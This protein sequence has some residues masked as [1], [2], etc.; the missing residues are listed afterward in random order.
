[1]SVGG[2][3]PGKGFHRVI[4]VLPALLQRFPGLVYLVVGGPSLAGDMRAAL[5][6]Q[7]AQL[8]LSE[9]VRFMG[10]I[11]PQDL[12]GIL[13]AADVFVL[14][15]ANE[16]WANVFLEAMACGLPVVTTDVGGNR[17][18]VC[19]AEVGA[20]VP[21]GDAGGLSDAL[22]AALEHPWDRQAIRRFAE[23]N[24]W[25]PRIDQIDAALTAMHQE[26]RRT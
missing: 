5:G 25:T 13:S 23:R 7:V 19:S 9:H 14:A 2:L 10:Q 15:T 16:G 21:F 4:E 18:V 22:T 8:G 1:M 20:L 12:A 3:V 24:S 6:A 17:E 26:H 11:A